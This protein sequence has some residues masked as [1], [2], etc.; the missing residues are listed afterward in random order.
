MFSVYL[1][2]HGCQM[3][4]SDAEVVWAILKEKGYQRTTD[5]AHVRN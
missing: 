1:D 2:V 5:P 4:V 3:N